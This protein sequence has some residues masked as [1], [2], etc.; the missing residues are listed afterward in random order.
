MNA[1]P[2]QDAL[3]DSIAETYADRDQR[4]VDL[5][6]QVHALRVEVA[7]LTEARD[8][9]VEGLREI[10]SGLLPEGPQSSRLHRIAARLIEQYGKKEGS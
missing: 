3:L 4:V 8:A 5:V 1:E 2:R 9:L 7:R 10:Y 6:A